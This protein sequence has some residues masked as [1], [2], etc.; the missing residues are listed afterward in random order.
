MQNV[1]TGISRPLRIRTKAI[2]TVCALAAGAMVIFSAPTLV[3]MF[4]PA[5]AAPSTHS[6]I[7][8]AGPSLIVHDRSEQ[9]LDATVA[10]PAAK[11]G[12]R[13]RAPKAL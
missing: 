12:P 8:V 6:S 7:T 13:H 3:N 1:S 11:V 10:A 2:V 5:K 4:A 9:G